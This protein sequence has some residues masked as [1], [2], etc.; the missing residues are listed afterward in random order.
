MP[1][2]NIASEISEPLIPQFIG[3]ISFE[4]FFTIQHQ[5]S[6]K[7]NI[8]TGMLIFFFFNA[9]FWKDF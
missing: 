8:L 7:Y 6:L 9:S 3:G 1:I 5:V 4:F 2:L